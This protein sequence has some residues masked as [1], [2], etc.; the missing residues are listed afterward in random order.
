VFIGESGLGVLACNKYVIMDGTFELVEEK[1]VLTTLMGYHNGIAILC[2]YYLSELKTHESYLLFFQVCN[3][4]LYSD[5]IVLTI[6]HAKDQK[7]Y[8]ELFIFNQLP[9]G[10]RESLGEWSFSTVLS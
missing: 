2:V 5:A 6:A 1:L 8:Q 10:F 7:T 4:K 9:A 3:K